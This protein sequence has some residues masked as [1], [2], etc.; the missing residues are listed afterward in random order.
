MVGQLVLLQ[1]YFGYSR[2]HAHF[3]YKL[4]TSCSIKTVSRF[5]MG[6][7]WNYTYIWGKLVSLQYQAFPMMD[8]DYLSIYSVLLLYLS[9]FHNLLTKVLHIV[10]EWFLGN[11]IFA[12][13][14]RISSSLQNIFLIGHPMIH[15]S[16]VH[17]LLIWTAKTNFDSSFSILMFIYFLVMVYWQM[18]RRTQVTK[19]NKFLF[20]P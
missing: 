8:N 19:S 11:R 5:W 12:L 1:T 2:T 4:K 3:P 20:C 16:F 17:R 15:L 10:L 13:G 7:H 18:S 14:T 9:V 6:F